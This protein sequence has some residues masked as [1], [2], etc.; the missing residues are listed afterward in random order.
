MLTGQYAHAHVQY[1]TVEY[2]RVQYSTAQYRT[3]ELLRGKQASYSYTLPK[4]LYQAGW[5]TALYGKWHVPIQNIHNSYQDYAVIDNSPFDFWRAQPTVRTSAT[6]N[7]KLQSLPPSHQFCDDW[8]THKSIDFLKNKWNKTNNFYMSTHFKACHEPFQ[9]PRD[10]MTSLQGTAFKE[11]PFFYDL[12]HP[13]GGK[14]TGVSW[15]RWVRTSSEYG[16]RR[17]S[18]GIGIPQYMVDGYFNVSLGWSEKK[19]WQENYQITMAL[20]LQCVV[21]LDRQ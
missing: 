7:Q 10:L 2:S 13:H 18:L 15:N 5:A 19:K 6:T 20:Y 8:F 16:Q 4:T 14:T 12:Q 9:S 1:S 11:P 21:G 17:E 3:T